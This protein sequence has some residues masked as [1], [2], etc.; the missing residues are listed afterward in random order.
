MLATP[1]LNVSQTAEAKS[2]VDL[3]NENKQDKSGIFE[4][5]RIT[6]ATGKG[7]ISQSTSASDGGTG[8]YNPWLIGGLG[9]G[10]LVFM[11]LLM[12]QR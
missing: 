12:R 3:N 10:G 2:A 6:V 4:Q 8:N 11:F 7:S 5:G 9:V 1:Q